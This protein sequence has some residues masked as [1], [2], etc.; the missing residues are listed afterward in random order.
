MEIGHMSNWICHFEARNY[1]CSPGIR[2]HSTTLHWWWRPAVWTCQESWN[3]ASHR[4]GKTSTAHSSGLAFVH[5]ACLPS[6]LRIL[7]KPKSGVWTSTLE[8]AESI[9]ILGCPN[10]HPPCVMVPTETTCCVSSAPWG[11]WNPSDASSI[12]IVAIQSNSSQGTPVQLLIKD[13][14][15]VKCAWEG[16]STN[17]AIWQ[18][19]TM[20]RDAKSTSYPHRLEN[21]CGWQKIGIQLSS[22]PW[23]M[24]FWHLSGCEPGRWHLGM[25]NP[26]GCWLKKHLLNHVTKICWISTSTADNNIAIVHINGDQRSQRLPSHQKHIQ[27]LAQTQCESLISIVSTVHYDTLCEDSCCPR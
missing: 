7:R 24:K 17:L 10:C 21:I 20:Q 11:W 19:K 4:L 27:A 25:T 26:L 15:S 14:K 5:C 13:H 3:L 18:W 6:V 23:K 22:Q 12:A 9:R 2:S 16:I 8:I 1:R